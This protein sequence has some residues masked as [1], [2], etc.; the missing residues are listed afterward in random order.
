[1]FYRS[2]RNKLKFICWRLRLTQEFDFKW[3]HGH[4]C[5]C[6]LVTK[7]WV[8]VHVGDVIIVWRNTHNNTKP[9]DSWFPVTLS[10][11]DANIKEI[12]VKFHTWKLYKSRLWGRRWKYFFSVPVYRLRRGEFFPPRI[13]RERPRTAYPYAVLQSVNLYPT[14]RPN[15]RDGHQI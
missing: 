10:D 3:R 2:I 13:S 11:T 12:R 14:L 5:R 1:M 7:H 9:N 15:T 6:L 4:H 8:K